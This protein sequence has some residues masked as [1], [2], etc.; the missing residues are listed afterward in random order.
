MSTMPLNRRF[1]VPT[2]GVVGSLLIGMAVTISPGRGSSL[3]WQA[4]AGQASASLFFAV[5][6]VLQSGLNVATRYVATS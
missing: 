1:T 3:T 6:A 4:L 2:H 5:L